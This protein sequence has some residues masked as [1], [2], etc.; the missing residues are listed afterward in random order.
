MSFWFGALKSSRGLMVPGKGSSPL[1]GFNLCTSFGEARH[2][3]RIDGHLELLFA[4]KLAL[5]SVST[6]RSIARG[7]GQWAVSSEHER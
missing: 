5:G 6:E 3:Y 7:S 1:S 2:S 4:R